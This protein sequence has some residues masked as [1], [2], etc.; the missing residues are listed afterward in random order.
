MY[1]ALFFY[2]KLF[3]LFTHYVSQDVLKNCQKIQ[4]SEPV[5][6]ELS[7]PLTIFLIFKNIC[8]NVVCKR[9]EKSL[10]QKLVNVSRDWIVQIKPLRRPVK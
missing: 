9:L 8:I 6:S 7:V 1:Y 10:F 3:F 2:K 5:R 4:G